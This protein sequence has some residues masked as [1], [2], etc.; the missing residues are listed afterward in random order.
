MN[1]LSGNTGNGQQSTQ[2]TTV[3]K[4]I[5]ATWPSVSGGDGVTWTEMEISLKVKVLVL[6]RHM[7]LKRDCEAKGD[8]E[9]GV[10]LGPAYL[11]G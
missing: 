2:S 9:K 4:K 11:G 6:V 10:G 5:L 8:A 3:Q 7:F 1:R